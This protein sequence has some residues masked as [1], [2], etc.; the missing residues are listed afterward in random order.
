MKKANVE[1]VMKGEDERSNQCYSFAIPL[2]DIRERERNR[3]ANRQITRLAK[4]QT[5]R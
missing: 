3:K 4:T 5:D 2:N 1:E